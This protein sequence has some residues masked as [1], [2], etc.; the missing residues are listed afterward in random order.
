[1]K[2]SIP[3]LGIAAAA[4]CKQGYPQYRSTCRLACRLDWQ[5]HRDRHLELVFGDFTLDTERKMLWR[6]TSYVPIGHRA[7][8]ILAALL[9]SPGH[10]ISKS[11]L[12]ERPGL[13]SAWMPPI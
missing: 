9:E 3:R 5:M 13:G 10:L 1:M 7:F 11:E 2:S 6:G 4:S 8:A 12:F